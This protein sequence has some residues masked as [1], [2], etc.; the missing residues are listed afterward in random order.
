MNKKPIAVLLAIVAAMLHIQLASAQD[1]YIDVA[2]FRLL[3]TDMDARIQAP[4]EDQNGEKCA[5]IKV[6]SNV[7]GLSF[8]SP[9]M[10]IVKQEENKGELWVYI[11][12]DSRSVSIFHEDFPPFRHYQYPVKIESARVYEMKVDGH[13]DP[14]DLAKN[15]QM[16]TINVQPST[17]LLFIDDEQMPTDNGLFTAMM[18]KGSH[19]YRVEAPHYEPKS[20][21]LDLEEKPVIRTVRLIE[22][23]GYLN[24]T[25]YPEAGA[26]VFVNEKLVGI[27]PYRS[28]GLDPKRYNVRVEKE[29]Y[30]PMDTTAVIATGGE[31]NEIVLN[32]SSTI[33]PKEG[34]KTFIIADAAMG[35]GNHTSFGVMIG[36]AA[37]SGAYLHLRSDFGSTDTSLECD[38]TGAL[39]SGGTGSP[40]YNGNS[41]KS[42]FSITAGYVHRLTLNNPFI[43]GHKGGL[44]AFAGV[45]YGDRTLAWETAANG[46]SDATKWVKNTDHS[47]SGVAAELGGICRMGSFALSLSYQTVMFKYHEATLGVGLFF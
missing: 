15:A 6:V 9:S 28:E 22:K 25:T 23:F 20:G 41:K 39:T 42:R 19:T 24:V 37:T 3:P 21:S 40:V 14:I 2:S 8:E 7:K 10:G 17:A 36:M 35:S 30:F 12:A 16:V 38:D 33:K 31:T 45:G 29:L 44:Y 32:M 26:K 1:R 34:R 27:T 11:P 4:V 13:Y 18:P 43:Y 5:L 47:A 46:I